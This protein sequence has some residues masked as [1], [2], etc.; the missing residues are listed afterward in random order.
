MVGTKVLVLSG[1]AAEGGHQLVVRV[2][3]IAHIQVGVLVVA[4]YEVDGQLVVAGVCQEPRQGVAQY[5]EQIEAVEISHQLLHVQLH[6][7][8]SILGQ[9]EHIYLITYTYIPL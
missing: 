8:E 4:V 6:P 9:E 3:A 5:I 1:G 7:K 2:E